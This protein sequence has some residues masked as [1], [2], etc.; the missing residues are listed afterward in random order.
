MP[1]TLHFDP[2]RPRCATPESSGKGVRRSEV[3]V[4]NQ[5]RE[6]CV[7]TPRFRSCYDLSMAKLALQ[8]ALGVR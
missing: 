7:K 1:E 3:I 8:G 6:E 5:S 4:D 2:T